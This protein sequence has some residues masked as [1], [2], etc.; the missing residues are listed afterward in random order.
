MEILENY[1]NRM[2]GTVVDVGGVQLVPDELAQFDDGVHRGFN[3]QA[4]IVVQDG[5]FR[6]LRQEAFSEEAYG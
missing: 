4:L 3:H 2:T 5:G 1:S 6:Q